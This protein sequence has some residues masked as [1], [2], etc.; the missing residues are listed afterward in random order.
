M[1]DYDVAIQY[2]ELSCDKMTK[3]LDIQWELNS[4]V[5]KKNLYSL[6]PRDTF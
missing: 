5:C 3:V 2:S 4:P 6:Y 1:A